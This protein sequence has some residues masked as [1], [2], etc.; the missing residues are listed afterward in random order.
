MQVHYAN[1]CK[2][3]ANSID[4]ILYIV[5]GST[6]VDFALQANLL[7][8]CFTRLHRNTLPDTQKYFECLCSRHN[9]LIVLLL[10]FQYLL[11]CVTVSS[12]M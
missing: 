6:E 1:L 4:H 2:Y 11:T 10:F 8:R 12:G 9:K 7:M 5:L 3:V